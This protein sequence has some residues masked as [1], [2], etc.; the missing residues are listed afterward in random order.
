MISLCLD[1]FLAAVAVG[2]FISGRYGVTRQLAAAP[3]ATAV[4]DIAFCTKVQACLTP[5][6]SALLLF[7]QLVILLGSAVVLYQDRVH[8]RNKCARRRRQRELGRSRAAFESAVA[9]KRRLCA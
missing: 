8:Y 6:L 2:M 7:L 4:V 1:M 5:A 3:L 9:R